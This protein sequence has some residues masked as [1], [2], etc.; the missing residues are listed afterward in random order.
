GVCASV[1]HKAYR[2]KFNVVCSMQLAHAILPLCLA[3]VGAG[4][5]GEFVPQVVSEAV[6][7]A[8][9]ASESASDAVDKAE[10]SVGHIKLLKE[11]LPQLSSK[12]DDAEKRA[13][14]ALKTAE[15]AQKKAEELL[16]TVE[17]Q[18]YQAA[19]KSARR[20]V[21]RLETDATGYYQSYLSDLKL[22]RV[23]EDI[24]QVEAIKKSKQPYTDAEE[25][26][27]ATVESYNS[28]AISLANE[29]VMYADKAKK[30]ADTAAQDQA[31]GSAVL[32]AKH[33][34][35][36]HKLMHMAKEKKVRALKVRALAE[37]LNSNVLPAYR[38][39]VKVAGVHAAFGQSQH[40]RKN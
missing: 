8:K 34:L 23:Q 25:Q 40:L 32:A 6:R 26:V 9:E 22:A 10:R 13:K 36:A 14:K 17:D 28:L 2:P 29:V 15:D 7:E 31:T 12:A 21:E 5:T 16:K 3:C 37:R 11:S 1:V 4:S 39:A 24:P 33:M 18:S 20:E 35:Q 30:L 19:S 38:Q 27:D